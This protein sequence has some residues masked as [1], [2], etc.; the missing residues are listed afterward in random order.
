LLLDATLGVGICGHPI[1]SVQLPD[2]EEERE[3]RITAMILGGDTII[4]LDNIPTGDVLGSPSLCSLL[5]SRIWKG[6]KLGVSEMP[7]YPNT[8]ILFGS[9]NNTRCTGEVAKRIVPIFL[10]PFDDHPEDR[11]NFVHTD[12][13]SYVRSKRRRLLSILLGMVEKWKREGCPGTDRRLGGFEPWAATIGGILKLHGFHQW[14]G[15]YRSWIR[16]ADEWAVDAES[17]ITAWWQSHGDRAIT[18]S[19]VLGVVRETGTFPRVLAHRDHSGQ[20]VVL[21][22]SVLTPLADRPVGRYRVVRD[23]YGSSSLY[24]L[25]PNDPEGQGDA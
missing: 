1:P 11:S 25:E 2:N 14:L 24:R 8:L 7:A 19:Q 3:K 22:R 23:Q 17:L 9:G 18:A 12:I 13:F 20:L 4:H 6:R 5:T 21:A 10:R 15:N 16:S